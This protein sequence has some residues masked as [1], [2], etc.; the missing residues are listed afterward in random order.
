MARRISRLPGKPGRRPAYLRQRGTARVP[1]AAKKSG[2][3]KAS[4]VVQAVGGLAIFVSLA[5]LVIGVRQFNE[6]QRE[7]AAQ[8][9]N[10]QRQATLNGY[11]NAMSGLVLQYHLT[12]SPPGAPVRAV[13]VARTATA[14]RDLDGQRKGTVVRFLWESHLI[15]RP[16]PVISLFHDDLNGA[17]FTNANFYQVYLGQVGLTNANF[18]GASLLGAYLRGAVLIQANLKNAKLACYNQIY[19]A[20]LSGAYLMRANLTGADLDGANLSG[21]YL[22]GANLSHAKLAGVKLQKA[23]YN[24]RSILVLNGQGKL[25][26]D[27]PTRWPRGFNPRAAGATCN[28]CQ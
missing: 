7:N 22:D 8:Q 4:V 24:T 10:Q 27:L 14:V 11:L 18:A 6:Q 17:V 1:E 26:T 28:F 9:L 19:C 2:W 23:V 13:A 16:H 25:V 20:N 21:A 3:D 5:A 15:S 12:K